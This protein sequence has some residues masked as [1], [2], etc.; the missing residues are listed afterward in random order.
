VE[1]P[2]LKEQV[3][4]IMDENP[5]V[6][7]CDGPMSY[8]L[9]FRFSKKSLEE[10]VRNIVKIVKKTD[11]REF[12]LD[13][14]LLRDLKWRDIIDK[15]HKV[16]KKK[17]VRVMTLADFAGEKNDILEARRKELYGD[18]KEDKDKEEK[19]GKTKRKKKKGKKG[20]SR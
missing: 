7:F 16:A 1:G 11:V 8:M 2:S 5:E 9:G 17:K 12:V 15:A 3:R 6:I 14:H 20:R 4:F 19:K 10:S 13:H 18:M